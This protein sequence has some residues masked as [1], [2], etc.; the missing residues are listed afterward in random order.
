[1]PKS[2][3]HM[4]RRIEMRYRSRKSP[5]RKGLQDMLLK[6]ESSASDRQSF[7]DF[8]SRAFNRVFNRGQRQEFRRQ[9]R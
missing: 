1:M 6:H 4:A 7:V 5:N 3:R 2:K 8:L 9:A